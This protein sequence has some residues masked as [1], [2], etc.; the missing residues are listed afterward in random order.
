MEKQHITQVCAENFQ[1]HVDTVLDMSPGVNAVVGLS[2]SGKSAFMRAL[3]WPLTNKPGGDSFRTIGA[4]GLTAVDITFADDLL[5]GRERDKS[6]NVYTIGPADGKD[7]KELPPGTGVPE[8]IAN[9]LNMG[10]INIQR[11]HDPPFLLADNPGEVAKVLNRVA[12]LTSIDKAQSAIRKRVLGVGADVRS[13]ETYLG[14]IEANQQGFSDLDDRATDLGR[15]EKLETALGELERK[16]IQLRQIV[17]NI[18]GKQSQLEGV[19]DFLEAEDVVEDAMKIMDALRAAEEKPKQL[20]QMIRT[21]VR[22]DREGAAAESRVN[23]LQTDLDVA[24]P[25]VC[26]LCDQEV[27]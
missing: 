23:R 4:K 3:A 1:S 16:A 7:L 13:A 11:Q 8:E 14:E 18:K 22:D 25:D 17:N 27:K 5:V 19:E 9:A 15:A 12:N 10:P 21:I 26:P 2:D 24:W 6:N 20:K